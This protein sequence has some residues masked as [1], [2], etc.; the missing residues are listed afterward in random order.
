MTRFGPT[1]LDQGFW[2][3]GGALQSQCDIALPLT[4]RDEWHHHWCVEHWT[5]SNWTVT[6]LRVSAT[7]T[8]TMAIIKHKRDTGSPALTNFSRIECTSINR[9]STFIFK[10]HKQS[11]DEFITVPIYFHKIINFIERGRRKSLFF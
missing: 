10:G 6:R 3:N 11:K 2:S 8:L 5:K 7:L 1:P 9:L 4:V